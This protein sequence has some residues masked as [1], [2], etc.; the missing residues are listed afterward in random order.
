[1]MNIGLIINAPIVVNLGENIMKGKYKDF[2]ESLIDDIN[3]MCPYDPNPLGGM[4][5]EEWGRYIHI[6]D[7]GDMKN[8]IKTFMND[9]EN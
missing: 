6:D 2:L 4:E 3:M 7:V 9:M 5:P 8:K 1:M